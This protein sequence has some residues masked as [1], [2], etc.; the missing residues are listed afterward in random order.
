MYLKLSLTLYLRFCFSNLVSGERYEVR[1]AAA[2][3]KPVPGYAAGRPVSEDAVL[4]SAAQRV[5]LRQEPADVRRHTLLLPE[6]RPA[7][8]ANHGAVGRVL[9]GDKVLRAWRTGHQ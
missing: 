9:R 2:D 3:V 8:A 5:L 7:E 6:R 4:R 1:D